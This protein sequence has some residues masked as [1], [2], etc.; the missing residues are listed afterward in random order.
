MKQNNK[1]T[2]KQAE[3][4]LNLSMRRTRK[5]EVLNEMN[6]V[7]PWVELVL[8]IAQQ[9]RAPGAKGGRPPFAVENMLRIHFIQQWFKLSNPAM[10]EALYDIAL[11]RKFVGLDPGEDYLPDESAVLRFRHLL[12]QHPAHC[13]AEFDQEQQ[14]RRP[15][16]APDRGELS[17]AL[18][19]QSADWYGCRFGS[20]ARGGGDCGQGQRRD[21]GLRAGGL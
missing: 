7:V 14:L 5:R 6:L 16:D 2:K 15:R 8:L 19:N 21:A 10:E 11:F 13:R 17:V 18:R 1:I 20:G 9:A 3:L 12:E 4:G